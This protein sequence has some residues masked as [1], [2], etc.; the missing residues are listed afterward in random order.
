MK[1]STT[2]AKIVL[3]AVMGVITSGGILSSVQPAN[4]ANRQMPC[5]N[6][7]HYYSSG[8]H[9]GNFDPFHFSHERF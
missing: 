5:H 1:S 7:T 2:I 6:I 9:D 4:A 8:N 3:A